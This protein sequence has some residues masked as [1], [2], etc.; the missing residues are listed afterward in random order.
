VAYPLK[1]VA[2]YLNNVDRRRARNQGGGVGE[3]MPAS[4]ASLV[5]FGDSITN[6]ANAT[7]GSEWRTLVADALGATQLNKGIAGTVLQNSNDSGGSPRA[8]NGRDR[9]VADLLGA[10]KQEMAIIAY[11]F[12]DARYIAAAATFNVAAFVGDYREILDGLIAGGYPLDRIVLVTPY[13]ITNTGLVT[14]STGFAGQTRAGF[15]L[16]VEAVRRLAREYGVYLADAYAAMLANG[17]DA[18]IGSDDIHPEDPGHLVIAN[19]I[20]AARRL[21]ATGDVTAPTILSADSFEMPN[22]FDA[23]LQLLADEP[24]TWTKTGGADA[25]L[26]T[27]TGSLLT[28]P[29]QTYASPADADANNQYEVV[30]TAT[31]AAGRTATQAITAV[32]LVTAGFLFDSFTDADNTVITAHTPEVGGSWVVQPGTAPPTA[33]LITSNRLRADANSGIYQAAGTPPTADYYVEARLRRMGT[34]S[35][36][37][38]VAGRMS[39]SANT[40]YFAHWSSVATG[41][42]LFKTVAGTSTQLGSTSSAAFNV[43]DEHTVRL[44]MDGSTIAM[45]VDG[46]ELVSVTDTA[47]TADGRAGVRFAENASASNGIHMDQIEAVPV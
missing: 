38:G 5:A 34:G 40:F 42:Q 9:Y 22:G 6:G 16:Y 27:L 12:N 7:A 23:S 25:S 24:V 36:R 14:G 20:L 45:S 29:A 43:G 17:G 44:T 1:A 3:P 30:V 11:G 37:V 47:I 28:L 26:F 8:D 18:L 21:P 46:V 13:Y 15:L 10:N 35:A 4:V 41:W 31:D 2:A 19:A 33:N 32:V 39:T